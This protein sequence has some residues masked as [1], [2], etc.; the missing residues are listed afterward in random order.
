MKSEILDP[1]GKEI[2]FEAV[3]LFRSCARDL[4]NTELWDAFYARFKRKIL[5]YLLRAFRMMGGNSDQFV[6]YS[7]DWMQDVFTKL[8]QN[9]GRVINSFR[10]TTENSIYAFLCSIALSIVADDLRAKGAVRRRA[11]LISLEQAHDSAAAVNP[12][13][14]R[15]AAALKLIDL[16][17][18]LQSGDESKNPER[19]LLI[20][21]L[22]FVEGLSAR[23]IASI[24]SLKLTTSGAEKVV[25]RVKN[26]LVRYQ[27]E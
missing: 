24:P 22:H 9:D 6:R 2:D 20:Y 10:G 23:E 5:L 25:G 27:K 7:D 1:A 3:E 13:D 11:Q 21:K 4:R 12:D 18:V 15:L 26:R 19:D 17:K 14:R 16:E 8:V